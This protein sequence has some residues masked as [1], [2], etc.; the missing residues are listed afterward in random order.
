MGRVQKAQS[1]RRKRRTFLISPGTL[2]VQLSANIIARPR[3]FLEGLKETRRN[4]SVRIAGLWAE[5]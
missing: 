3:I 5:I 1:R 2:A 4:T